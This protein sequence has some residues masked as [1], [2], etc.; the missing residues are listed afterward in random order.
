[1]TRYVTREDTV[2]EFHKAMGMDRIR[3][4]SLDLIDLRMN[5]IHE[6]VLELKEAVDDVA[7]RLWYHKAVLPEM[8]SQILKELADLQYVISGFADAFGLPLQVA[9]N[10]VHASNMSKLVDGKPLKR[11]D[12]KVLKG[13]NYTPPDLTDL[14]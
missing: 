5:L 1:M 8:R 11:K 6:E 2:S 9:F 14:V 13:P 10:R 12:G 7:C 4:Y 3:P